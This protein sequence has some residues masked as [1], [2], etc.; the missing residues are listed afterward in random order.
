[1]LQ[2]VFAFRY[3]VFLEIYPQ[4]LQK[5][6]FSGGVE[7]DEYD[8]YAVHFAALDE[9]G[10]VCATVRLIYN[11][12]IGYPTEN[13]M[14]FDKSIFE[15][16]K[17]AEMSRIFID[18]KYRNLETT[19]LIIEEAKKF[20]YVRMSKLGIK[21]SYG[22][23]EKNF[24]RLLRIYKMSYDIIGEAQ[25]HGEFGLRYPCVLYTKVLGNDNPKL[26]KFLETDET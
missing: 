17:L 20:M 4:Y 22:S 9:D 13:S 2:K 23:L 6:S 11:S 14:I 24:L 12:P 7:H 26:I 16:D 5:A 15:R 3:K 21:Y 1:M 25:M 19:K 10:V 8:L 18:S